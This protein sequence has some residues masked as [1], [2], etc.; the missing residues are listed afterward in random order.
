MEVEGAK[1][2]VNARPGRVVLADLSL[3]LVKA[4]AGGFVASLVASGIVLA[5]VGLG[6]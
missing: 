4:L 3:V 1:V 2:Q 6:G 5:L